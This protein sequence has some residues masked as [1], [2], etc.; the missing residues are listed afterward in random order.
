MNPMEMKKA[1]NVNAM[2]KTFE[3]VPLD[4]NLPESFYYDNT[5]AIRTGDEWDS[6]LENLFQACST[7]LN[8]KA[9]LLL[10]HR[11]CGKSTEL[12]KLKQKFEEAGQPVKI[13]DVMADAALAKIDHWDIMLLITEGLCHI[14]DAKS[15]DLPPE[16]VKTISDCLIEDREVITQS[17]SSD[18]SGVSVGA[19]ATTPPILSSIIKLFAEIKYDQKTSESVRTSVR[20]KWSG[21]HLN[22]S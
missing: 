1:E 15:I 9:H 12:Y 2:L 21:V 17:E 7:S 16:T 8:A 6:P 14:A 4:E 11:G 10:G 5:M 13:I 3:P 19:K 18:S 20:K 22:G